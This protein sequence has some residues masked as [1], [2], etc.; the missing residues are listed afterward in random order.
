MKDKQSLIQDIRTGKIDINNQELFFST[1]IKGLMSKLDDNIRIRGIEIPHIILH[2]GDSTMHQILSN[3]GNTGDIS[4]MEEIYNIIPRCIIDVNNID[5]SVDQLSSPYSMGLM[6]YECS[7][8][9]YSFMGE[10]RRYPI[11]LSC[12]LKYYVDSYTDMLALFQQIITK[13]SFIQTY[14][15]AYMGQTIVNSYK[16]PDSFDGEHLMEIDG[17]TTDSKYK[18]VTCTIEIESTLPVWDHKTLV[19]NDCRIS[20]PILAVY[21]TDEP[22]TQENPQ[23]GIRIYGENGIKQNSQYEIG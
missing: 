13:L 2:T 5:L 11:K 18:T 6:Q 20:N 10:F 14:N 9:V 8:G 12:E 16:T 21:K 17:T 7:D 1:L 3:E 19:Y 22:L 23:K 4:S 15:I